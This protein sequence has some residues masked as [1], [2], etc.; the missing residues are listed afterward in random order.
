M[1][2]FTN[3]KLPVST[4]AKESAPLLLI[5]KLAAAPVSV[6]VPLPVML[7]TCCANPTRSKVPELA[8]AVLIGKALAMPFAIVPAEIVVVPV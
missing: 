4:P 2:D 8:N 5:V 1:L 3:A 7:A 6:T